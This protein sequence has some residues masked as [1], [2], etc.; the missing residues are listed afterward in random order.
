[1]HAQLEKLLEIQDLKTQRRELRIDERAHERDQAARGPHAEDQRRGVHVLRDHGR[2]DEDAR[3]DDAAHD[4]HGRVE[5]AEAAGERGGGHGRTVADAADNPSSA[6]GTFSPHEG[7]RQPERKWPSPL[8]RGEKVP[9]AD[10]G[11]FAPLSSSL[12]RSLRIVRLAD[13]RLRCGAG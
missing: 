10:E 2:I 4:Q 5:R 11:S 9:Q 8:R 13:D 1:M 6:C 3:A 7:R 12:A